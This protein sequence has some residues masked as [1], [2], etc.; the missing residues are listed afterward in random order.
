MDNKAKELEIYSKG[1]YPANVLSNFAPNGFDLDGV[2][3]ACMEGFLQSL[4]FRNPQKQLKVCALFG[5]E[6]KAVGSKKII[7]KLTGNVW[8]Q[9]AR[10]KRIG[11]EF[12]NLIFR[13]YK[14]LYTNSDFSRAL[15]STNGIQLKH[16]IGKH[17]KHKTILTEEEFV[18]ILTLLRDDK[19]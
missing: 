16:S 5:K 17:N 18:Q 2:K 11:D 3:C 14:A 19:N 13:A 4:K 8:W 6:A 7:W 12:N 15:D 1:E 9:G 10:I